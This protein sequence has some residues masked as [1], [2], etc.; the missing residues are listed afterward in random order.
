MIAVGIYSLRKARTLNGFFLADRK[1]G[2]VF[3]A[4]SLTATIIGGSNTIGMAGL[5][6]RQG[7]TGSLWLLVG[8][9]GLFVLAIFLAKKVRKYS[10]YTLPELVE[11]LYDKR[12]KLIASILVCFSWLAIVAGQM[13]AAGAILSVLIPASSSFLVVLFSL[14]LITYTI[15]GGQYSIIRTDF[16]QL[17]IIVAGIL[18]ATL[19]ALTRLGGMS[20]LI[21]QL[22]KEFFSFPTGVNFS[23]W[24]L[25]SLTVLVGAAYLVGPDIYSRL[26]CA[27]DEK[28][29]RLSAFSAGIIIIPLAFLITT[30]GMCARILFPEIEAQQAFPMIIQEVFPEGVGGLVIASLLAAL[31]SS[32]DTCLLTISTILTMD[33]YRPYWSQ[34][35]SERRLLVFSR[36]VVILVG[37]ISLLIALLIKGIIPALLLGYT[38]F[39]SGLAIPIIAGFYRDRL[40]LNST[41]ALAAIIG[42]GGFA[43]TGKLIGATHCGLIGFAVSGILLF[44]ISRMT[45]S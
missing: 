42:G 3:V 26:F 28:T 7:L 36:G 11:K 18:F 34:N 15:L 45:K 29:A 32:A 17:M 10:L 43:L 40:R 12:V 20:G 25:L 1:M 14:V 23:W 39:T 30:V 27:K 24:D 44:G 2:K 21:D 6:F 5:G 35:F 38:V 19:L 9:F 31:M 33:I 8:S 16:I 13:I 37:L 4:A 41:G 22:P